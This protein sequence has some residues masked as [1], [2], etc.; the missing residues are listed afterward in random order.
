MT[1]L[2]Y[3]ASPGNV[4]KALDALKKAATPP[5]VSQDFVKTK[6]GIP[7]SS[8]DQ[9]TSFLKR[10]GF[11]TSDGTPTDLYKK[12]RTANGGTALAAGIRQAY[13]EMYDHNE[14][15]HDCN[16]NE[17]RDL[18]IQ[19]TGMEADS[20][21]VGL[22][23]ATLRGLIDAADFSETEQIEVENPR[24]RPESKSETSDAFPM[25]AFSQG[26]SKSNDV[27]LNIGYT[28][29]LN[30]PETA[31]IEVFNAIFKSLKEHL[32]RSDDV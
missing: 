14:Y 6:L 12:Y 5:R 27:G 11:A 24:N 16:E 9:M 29:N 21:P 2:P 15:M 3:L 8:G 25:P 26:P 23:Y 28:I 13:S 30:L 7:G 32:L 18:I 31:N 20:R 4:P 10:I 1:K 17:M 19:V 22:I